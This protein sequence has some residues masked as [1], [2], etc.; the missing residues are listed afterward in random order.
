MVN[1]VGGGQLTKV[2]AVLIAGLLALGLTSTGHAADRTA[3]P[4]AKCETVPARY[5]QIDLTRLCDLKWQSTYQIAESGKKAGGGQGIAGGGDASEIAQKSSNPLGGD[6]MLIINEFN[7]N[8]NTGSLTDHTRSSVVHILQPVI[9]FSL[10][11]TIG[12]DW[13]NVNRPTLPL[14]YKQPIPGIDLSGP[15]PK[16]DFSE[17]A[18]VGD[19]SHFSLV[20]ISRSMKSDTLGQGDLVAAGGVSINFPS[21]SEKFT[22]NAWA[23]GP[24]GVLAWIGKKVIFG[25]LIQSQL[26]FA[27]RGSKDVDYDRIFL[28]VFYFVPLGDGWQVG[29]APLMTFDLNKY[30]HQIPL[31]IGVQ[32]VHIF[33]LGG[34]KKMP[35]R[36]GLE[37]RY[38]FAKNNAFG[39]RWSVVFS[40]TPILPNILSNLFNGCPA[41]S[42]GGC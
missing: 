41:M 36:F 11:E 22:T 28:Q 6:F 12:P 32:K 21:G 7:F 4:S 18:G 24:A 10:R 23:A 14:I 16:V 31:G 34:G 9:P 30:E 26:K 39:P 3:M 5:M 42:I 29:G 37:G 17:H 1:K 38:H 27:N 2:T 13:I 8:F 35:V 19:I 15:T 33:D 40:V 20:G 25:A